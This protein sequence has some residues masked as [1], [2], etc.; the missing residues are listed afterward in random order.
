MQLALP[1]RRSREYVEWLVVEIGRLAVYLRHTDALDADGFI[2]AQMA[3]DLA[4][5]RPEAMARAFALIRRESKWLPKTVEFLE[6]HDRAAKQLR[7]ESE[8]AS[9]RAELA[10]DARVAEDRRLHPENYFSFDDII[11]AAASKLSMDRPRT[12]SPS[13]SSAHVAPPAPSAA[14]GRC[15]MCECPLGKGQ[16]RRCQTCDAMICKRKG[17]CASLHRALHHV[18]ARKEAQA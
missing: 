4:D 15:A 5:T 17:D 1:V 16:F 13:Q 18:A 10:E 11:K 6:F 7:E 8:A 9:R 14:L 2:A 12:P 3:E